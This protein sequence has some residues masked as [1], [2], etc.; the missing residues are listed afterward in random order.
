[1]SRKFSV[2]EYHQM[3]RAG[4][5]D[6]NDNVELIRGDIVLKPPKTTRRCSCVDRMNDLFFRRLSRRAIISIH[7]P[8]RLHDSEPEPAVM[9]L[10]PK[11][12]FYES[13]K[14]RPPDVLLLIEVSDTSIDYDRAVKGTLYAKA[15][16]GEFWILNLND[17]TLEVYRDPQADGT[18]RDVRI[19]RRGDQ[20]EIAALPGVVVQVDELL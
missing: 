13:G 12:D 15:N 5:L 4:I 16:I 10:R 20:I 2:A 8:V 7:D 19:L 6:E 9:L 18:Y 11:A 3:I 1:M 14:P 17:D